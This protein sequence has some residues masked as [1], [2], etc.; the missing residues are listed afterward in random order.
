MCIDRSG[1]VYIYRH[2]HFEESMFPYSDKQS[3]T[4]TFFDTNDSC[5]LLPFTT[6]SC[7][8]PGSTGIPM[9]TPAFETDGNSRSPRVLVDLIESCSP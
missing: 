2:V 9:P 7:F 1:R 5:P 6:D 8:L 4:T 3:V